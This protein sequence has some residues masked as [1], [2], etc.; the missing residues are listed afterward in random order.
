MDEEP[1]RKRPLLVDPTLLAETSDARLDPQQP[2]R[3]PH[4]TTDYDPSA[5]LHVNF[6]WLDVDEDMHCAWLK[7]DDTIL[8][9]FNFMLAPEVVIEPP[10]D[11][12]NPRHNHLCFHKLTALCPKSATEC[13]LMA[14][15]DRG[16]VPSMI[17]RSIAEKLQI[18]ITTRKPT[19]VQGIGGV[20]TVTEECLLFIRIAGHSMRPGISSDE[21][22]FG[23]RCLVARE[24][25]VPLLIG[26]VTME[27]CGFVNNDPARETTFGN[28]HT[29][30]HMT[31][32]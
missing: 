10:T 32:S 27:N 18:P 5:V 19:P 15:F 9:N 8:A 22:L 20:I 2:L 21:G 17:N 1:S 11:Y 24:C 3:R 16:A 7:E 23:V 30:I 31:R 25:P 12:F 14:Q 13:T 28:A 26:S 6:A 4:H 29:F